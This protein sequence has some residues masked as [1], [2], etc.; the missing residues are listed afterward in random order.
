MKKKP[1]YTL[2]NA[3]H[4]EGMETPTSDENWITAVTALHNTD[5]I[6]SGTDMSYGIYPKYLAKLNSYYIYPEI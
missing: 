3:H 6:A 4:R 5:L 1:L 2:R